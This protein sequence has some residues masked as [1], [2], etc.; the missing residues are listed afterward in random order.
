MNTV[1]K[2]I[3]DFNK[4]AKKEREKNEKLVFDVTS[5]WTEMDPNQI[6]VK[7][8]FADVN[9]TLFE[10]GIIEISHKSLPQSIA[11]DGKRIY[12]SDVQMNQVYLYE[13]MNFLGKLYHQVV[14]YAKKGGSALS[15]DNRLKRREIQISSVK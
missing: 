8:N 6:P 10:G 7:A 14:S 9:L 11:V 4:E 13:D 1:N 3:E 15:R 5:M 2:I 12:V